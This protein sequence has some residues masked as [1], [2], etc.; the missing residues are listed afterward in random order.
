MPKAPPPLGLAFDLRPARLR[1]CR[2]HRLEALLVEARAHHRARVVVAVDPTV[3]HEVV[4]FGLHVA[5]NSDACTSVARQRDPYAQG[6]NKFDCA[7]MQDIHIQCLEHQDIG[8]R[9]GYGFV[10]CD[11]FSNDPCTLDN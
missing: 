5:A 3:V 6:E 11:R 10:G 4:M 8:T 9:H 1:H 7:D 2:P